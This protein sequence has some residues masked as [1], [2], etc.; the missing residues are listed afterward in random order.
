MQFIHIYTCLIV[1]NLFINTGSATVTL[2]R[3]VAH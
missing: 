1:G 2:F 3:F